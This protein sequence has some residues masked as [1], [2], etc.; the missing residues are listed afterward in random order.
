MTRCPSNVVKTRPEDILWLCHR[1]R[2]DELVQLDALTDMSSDDLPVYFLGKTGPKFTVLDANGYPVVAGGFESVSA[3]VL[4]S[5]ML[6]REGGW[7]T[8]WRSITKASR[9]L[10]D[11][12]L[13]QPEIRRLQT[14][15]LASRV[16]A[17]RWYVDGL[18]MKPE[19]V[20]RA[21]GSNGVDAA[22]F[23]RIKGD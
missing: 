3:G 10:M 13:A 7:D 20:W 18:G 11:T 22:A 15:A 6:G 4:Q 1:M 16:E 8:H 14:V 19:G 2:A 9:W 5:W 21:Y 23:S 12:L 17:C